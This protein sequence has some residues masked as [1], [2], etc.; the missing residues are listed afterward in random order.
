MKRIIALHLADYYLLNHLLIS[1]TLYSGSCAGNC[2][3]TFICYC[4]PGCIEAGQCCEDFMTEC[5]EVY[6]VIYLI[7]IKL[8]FE[9]LLG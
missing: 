7:Q 9:L 6:V 3:N 8:V 2:G 4:D 1:L 5:P